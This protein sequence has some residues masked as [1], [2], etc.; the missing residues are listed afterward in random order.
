MSDYSIFLDDTRDPPSS[1]KGEVVVA[2]TYEQFIAALLR[3]G[4]PKFI[5]FDH[6][7][8]PVDEQPS[9]MDCAKAFVENVLN[10]RDWLHPDFSFTVHS[11][12]PAGAANINGLMSRFLEFLAEERYGD[13]RRLVKE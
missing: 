12:N 2:R 6:D 5:S 10:N 3:Y 8:G 7:L 13:I 4:C 9:G 1:L 11:M